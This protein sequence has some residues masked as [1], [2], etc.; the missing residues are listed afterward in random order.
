MMVMHQRRYSTR[1]TQAARLIARGAIGRPHTVL[2]RG[3]GGLTNTHSHTV[4]MMRY[5]LGDPQAEWVMA[6]LERRTNRWER[7]HPIEDCLV[8]VVAFA[9]GVQGIIQSDLPGVD[10]GMG[11]FAYGTEGTLDLFGGPR[12]MNR[13]T[14]G[15]WQL[16]ERKEIDPPVCYCR[17][18][19]RW[20][21]GGPEPRISLRH[22][23]VTHEIL[24]GIYESARTRRRVAFPIKNR[25][26]I[27]E[28]MIA[29][30]DLPLAKRKP[31][32]IRTQEAF[33]AGYR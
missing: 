2:A 29:A 16:I 22:A 17:D 11:L 5:V 3:E 28:Q 26:R 33:K 4:D 10:G 18:L 13:K 23:L 15:T 19:A 31:Y 30:G 24:M 1:F 21:G 25:R 6:Q 20:L 8:A 9:G 32:D 12:L 14:G 7:C 27:I